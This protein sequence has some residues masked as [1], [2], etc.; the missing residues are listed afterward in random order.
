M[1]GQ[2]V[3]TERSESQHS[4]LDLRSTLQL[5]QVMNE[6]DATV[7]AAV[8]ACAEPLAAAIEAIVER[9]AAGGRLVYV[10]AGTCGRIAQMDA[11]ECGPTFGFPPDR[12]VAVAGPDGAP[13]DDPAAGAAAVAEI[14]VGDADAVVLISASGGTPYT[15]GAA[16][17]AAARGAL[18]VAVV[19]APASELAALADH[20]VLAQTGAEVIVGSTRLKAGTAQKL[21]LNTISTVSMIRLGRTYGNLMVDVVATN[22]KL[23]A[24]ARRTVSLATAAADGQ[25]DEALAA[26]DGD[27]KVAILSLLTGLPAADARARLEAAD[28]VL[29]RAVDGA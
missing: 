10:G 5:V 4:D 27:A 11:A 26:A 19:S 25:I 18:T 8:R 14:A 13:E 20:E 29:R 15:V 12:V 6:A 9:L 24:R 28:G 1:M 22:D 7:A 23:R 21:I 16:R 3:A 17:A 2:D